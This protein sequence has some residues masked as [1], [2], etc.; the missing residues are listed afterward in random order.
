MENF[1]YLQQ[2]IEREREGER[3]HVWLTG[4]ADF[5]V[6]NTACSLCR[7]CDGWWCETAAQSTNTASSFRPKEK[8]KKRIYIITKY[9]GR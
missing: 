4:A 5:R 7:V 8:R 1:N 2:K 9:T 6:D 3:S